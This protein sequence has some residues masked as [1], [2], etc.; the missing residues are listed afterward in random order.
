MLR[1]VR[2]ASHWRSVDF[3]SDLHLH[4]ED[5]D[6]AQA[7]QDYLANTPAD[8]VFILG[9]L[10]EVWPGDDCLEA[11]S[12]QVAPAPGHR[13]A[14]RAEACAETSSAKTRAFARACA[15]ALRVA[16]GRL[17]L[18]FLHGNRD[19]LLGSGFAA[20]TGAQLLADPVVLDFGP[21][22]VLLSHGDALCLDDVDYQRFRAQ[23]RDPAWIGALLQRPL[24]EREALGRQLRAQSDAR[25]AAQPTYA[26]ADTALAC[27]WLRVAGAQVLVHGHTHRPADHDLGDG[28]IRQVLSDWDARAQPPRAQALRLTA[29]GQ[30]QRV[31]LLP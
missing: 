5:P 9:D 22:K 8:A 29:E 17:D 15:A 23:V 7:W 30:F 18:H 27:R 26:D 21:R 14:S 16:S 19:F 13:A 2:A 11:P 20:A 31:N 12:D 6:T 10:F 24:A 25:H 28:L 4:P 3:I 1:E